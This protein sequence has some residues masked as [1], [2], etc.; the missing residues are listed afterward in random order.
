MLKIDNHKN[1]ENITYKI[2]L[3]TEINDTE[4]KLLAERKDEL[5]G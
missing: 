5:Q 3:L 1:G 2:K 4:Y